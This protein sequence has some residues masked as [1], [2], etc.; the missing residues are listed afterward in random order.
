VDSVA[1]AP[2]LGRPTRSVFAVVEGS[3]RTSCVGRKN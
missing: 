1:V 3:R 2:K